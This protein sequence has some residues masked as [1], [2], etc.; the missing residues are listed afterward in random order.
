MNLRSLVSG[1]APK[2]G[3][4][5]L[6]LGACVGAI[7]LIALL[8]S[9]VSLAVAVTADFP[10][11]P[12]SHPYY[13]AV[14]D[15]AS[16][17]IIG[18]YANGN[19]GI[20]DNVTRQQFAKMAVLTG[21][22]PVSESDVCAFTD[23]QKGGYA[24][25]FYPDNYVAVCASNAITTGKTS[26]TFD[27]SGKITRY[28]AIS[29]V[30]RMADN[31]R[32]GL[33]ATPP[34][35]WTSQ[36]GWAG[37]ATHGTN[38]LRAEYNGLLA[39]FDFVPMNPN[40]YMTRGEVAQLL[41]NLLAKMGTPG[42]TTTTAGTTTTTAV[43][44]TGYEN[45]GGNCALGSAPAVCSRG[46]GR[47]DVFIRDASGT[48]QW[49]SYSSPWSAWSALAGNQ[50][51]F[52]T[53]YD[54]AAVAWGPNTANISVFSVA[55]DSSV[56]RKTYSGPSS[57]SFSWSPW[58]DLSGVAS[59]S[60]PAAVSPHGTRIF[61]AVRALDNHCWVNRK[62]DGPDFVG[63]EDLGGNLTAAPAICSAEPGCL[64][65]VVRDQGNMLFAKVWEEDPEPDGTWSDWMAVGGPVASAPA[66]VCQG[67]ENIQ[68]FAA[69]P[70]SKL[71]Q[72]MRTGSGWVGPTNL[73]GDC[74]S[75]PAVIASEGLQRI[76]VFVRTSQKKLA[77]VT[78]SNG[79][80]SSWT[81]LA[82]TVQFG[83][84]PKAISW[85]TNRIDLFAVGSDGALWHKYW[86]GSSWKP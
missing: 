31:L 59:A 69:S 60:A 8:V 44:A 5:R 17:G 30:V 35:G 3:R 45:L 13:A 48:V 58:N 64:V 51:G 32:P 24:D 1:S 36:T 41:H 66:C 10:D 15:L 75:T 55:L 79:T 71:Y 28:Q 61:V 63:W 74:V 82:G 20:N 50:P 25:P 27:P 53:K 22:Y 56:P 46:T 38:A 6:A 52:S 43:A 54:P 83:G 72:F 84:D 23:V 47:L 21:G 76:D 57:S 39:N 7:V 49:K 77:T 11:V 26:T 18:G 81:T 42:T 16:R 67:K 65:V 40:D 73:G 68:V 78:R 86:D 70:D 2:S 29:M 37:N 85:G 9:V 34:D 19:F 80:W 62:D 12:P 33:L 4:R 14:M